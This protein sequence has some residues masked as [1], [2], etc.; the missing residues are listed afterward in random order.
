[1]R[2]ILLS[3]MVFLFMGLTAAHATTWYA[4]TS[5][6]NWSAN[7]WTSISADQ[8]TCLAA[9]GTPVAGDTAILNSSSGNITITGAAAAANMDETGYTGT[10]AFG[11]Q[12]LTLTGTASLASA[13]TSTSGTLSVGGNVTLLSTVTGSFPTLALTQSLTFTSGGFTWPGNVTLASGKT[14]TTVGAVIINGNFLPVNNSSVF[15]LSLGG[16][17]TILGTMQY[18]NSSPTTFWSGAFNVSIGTLQIGSSAFFQGM[19]L[20]WPAGQTLTVT[21][22][23]LLSDGALPGIFIT[24]KSATSSSAA[25]LNYTGTAANCNVYNITFTDIDASGSTQAIQNYYGGTLTRTANITNVNQSNI[26]GSG[27]GLGYAY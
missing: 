25:F 15:S 26:S 7:V 4:C 5:G 13:M 2:K 6:G 19:T 18:W 9:L 11:T 3:L 1:M 8:G 14:I 17:L 27:S 23:L 20:Q 12:T 22:A 16:N 10:L 21:T 24:L